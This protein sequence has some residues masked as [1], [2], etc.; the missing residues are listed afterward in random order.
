[1]PKD[2]ENIKADAKKKQK[3]LP[4]QDNPNLSEI[5]KQ[6]MTNVYNFKPTK[7][8]FLKINSIKRLF[9]KIRSFFGNFFFNLKFSKN[10]DAF[11][12][13]NT[14][15]NGDV[16]PEDIQA[17]KAFHRELLREERA[18]MAA[19]QINKK[20]V[21][22]K[23]TILDKFLQFE[24]T[25]LD[26]H[27]SEMRYPVTD[28]FKEQMFYNKISTDDICSILSYESEAKV[29]YD[30]QNEKFNFIFNVEQGVGVV[31]VDKE[32][33]I[34][35]P[36]T[37]DEQFNAFC[38]IDGDEPKYVGYVR[39]TLNLIDINEL[40]YVVNDENLST[41]NISIIS[42]FLNENKSDIPKEMFDK[43]QNVINGINANHLSGKSILAM[44]RAFSDVVNN[45]MLTT[46]EK[47]QY[48]LI[49]PNNTIKNLENPLQ[50][51]AVSLLT[52]KAKNVFL[53]TADCF[54]TANNLFNIIDKDKLSENFIYNPPFIKAIDDIA[55]FVNECG[56]SIEDAT[57]IVNTYVNAEDIYSY[58]INGSIAYG[59]FQ[60]NYNNLSIEN[61]NSETKLSKE[62]LK[63]KAFEMMDLS[64]R[65]DRVTVE[66]MQNFIKDIITEIE[67]EITNNN[68][69]TDLQI[70][71]DVYVFFSVLSDKQLSSIELTTAQNK[72]LV[73]LID[74]ADHDKAELVK[75]EFDK[76]INDHEAPKTNRSSNQTSVV[77]ISDYTNNDER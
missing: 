7:Y 69:V 16:V 40:F 71:L 3:Q 32:G 30:K 8:D 18:R 27:V 25:T 4:N 21:I 13:N 20:E 77:D 31:E 6:R 11:V 45:P 53:D 52:E 34:S 61:E 19:E 74:K 66:M 56:L 2:N 5:N 67:Y 76:K 48:G 10:R 22:N 26:R 46:N 55:N 37:F 75:I 15:K 63:Q 17:T 38:M 62:E 33:N 51:R 54:D 36:E 14:P 24:K 47:L 60:S 65:P 29:V 23:E 73:N 72:I 1:M 35:Y 49:N 28:F 39:D 44:N 70:P 59:E 42:D 9:Q 68:N 50:Y 43:C 12:E 41:S 58:N 57:K 64:K